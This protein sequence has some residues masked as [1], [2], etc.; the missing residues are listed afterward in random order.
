LASE[1]HLPV[2]DWHHLAWTL[3]LMRAIRSSGLAEVD[4]LKFH[5]LQFFS[6]S[7]ARIYGEQPPVELV[8]KLERGPFY[9]DA[10]DDIDTLSVCGLATVRDIKWHSKG[11]RIWKTAVYGL[12]NEGFELCGRL[13][14]DSLWCQDVGAFLHDLAMAYSDLSD[15]VLDTVAL[16]DLTYSQRGIAF[17]DIIPFKAGG[18]LSVRATGALAAMLPAAFAPNR[19]NRLRTYLKY[20]EQLAA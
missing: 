16:K 12:T 19:R 4:S 10:Q 15:G 7:L 9:P 14:G 13:T 18:N 3:L 1:F 5:R 17:G 20:L 2:R 8:M 6:N 11:S